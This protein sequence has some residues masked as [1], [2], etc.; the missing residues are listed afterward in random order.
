[1]N[2]LHGVQ[3]SNLNLSTSSGSLPSVRVQAIVWLAGA[4]AHDMDMIVYLVQ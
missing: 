4:G 1:M 2:K 3:R